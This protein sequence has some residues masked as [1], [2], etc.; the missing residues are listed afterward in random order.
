M[1]CCLLSRASLLCEFTGVIPCADVGAEY[2]VRFGVRNDREP[3]L[4][5]VRGITENFVL[6]CVR[7]EDIRGTSIPW[8][9]YTIRRCRHFLG[10]RLI[11][12]MIPVTSNI[13]N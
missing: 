1:L 6:Y 10:L 7:K 2:A 13:K 4:G 11:F 8:A 12:N 5:S 3:F 9:R